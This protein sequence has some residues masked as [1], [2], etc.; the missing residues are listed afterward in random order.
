MFI[1]EIRKTDI[2]GKWLDGLLDVRAR[3]RILARVERLAA[4]NPGDTRP[5][6]KGV[7]ELRVDYGPGY[8][9]Y[10]KNRG[11]ELVILLAGGDKRTQ[12]GDIKT[13]LRLA[14][15]L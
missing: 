11:Q 7:S 8:R 2:Y 15:N 14:R 5:V 3:A 6:G 10:Y 1:K 12:T 9:V 13:A 4:G